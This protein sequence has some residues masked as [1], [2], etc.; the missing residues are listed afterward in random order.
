MHEIDITLIYWTDFSCLR[1]PSERKRERERDTNLQF[2]QHLN[3]IN[4]TKQK[5][6]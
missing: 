2:L 5:K 3:I 1:Q 6:T 4:K